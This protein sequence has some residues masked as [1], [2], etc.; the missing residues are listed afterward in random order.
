LSGKATV[1][2]LVSTVAISK[3]IMRIP[4]HGGPLAE[5]TVGFV[6]T[7][8]YFLE[9]SGYLAKEIDMTTHSGNCRGGDSH[10]SSP[11]SNSSPSQTG[12]AQGST[13]P[14]APPPHDNGPTALVTVDGSLGHNN[15]DVRANL[16]AGDP[17]QAALVAMAADGSIGHNGVDISANLAAL[18][19]ADV[20]TDLHVGLDLGHD[21][22]HA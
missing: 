22:Y 5:T 17:H 10:T 21:C 16:T 20:H 19:V 14:C 1:I 3:A 15:V 7:F 12:S 8:A 13:N 18:N 4:S 2:V 9:Q 11:S 6:I